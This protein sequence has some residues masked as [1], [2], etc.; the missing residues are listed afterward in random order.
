LLWYNIIINNSI[1]TLADLRLNPFLL[2]FSGIRCARFLS[3]AAA[4]FSTYDHVRSNT[5]LEHVW[6]KGSRLLF[7]FQNR[8][9]LV[10]R[11]SEKLYTWS[12]Y[13]A[14][15]IIMMYIMSFGVFYHR[16][17]ILMWCTQYHTRVYKNI[18]PNSA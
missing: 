13:R 17:S 10:T 2:V 8:S 5:V 3:R 14:F 1:N 4:A 15:W 7:W 12:V 6:S 18:W 9:Q 16:T 11:S